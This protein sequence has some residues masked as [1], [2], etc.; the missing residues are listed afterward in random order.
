MGGGIQTSNGKA[1]EYACVLALCEQLDN[2]QQIIIETSPQMETAQKLY[3]E[4]SEEMNR[5]FSLCK[6]MQQG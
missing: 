2:G 1:F 5:Y 4:M 6:R 3:D